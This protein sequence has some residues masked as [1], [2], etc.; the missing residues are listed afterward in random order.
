[1]IPLS[2]H[3][4]LCYAANEFLSLLLWL[5]ALC[6]YQAVAK[7]SLSVSLHRSSHSSLLLLFFVVI[8]FGSSFFFI[9]EEKKDYNNKY[10][11]VMMMAFRCAPVRTNYTNALF[12]SITSIVSLFFVHLFLFI[13]QIF[14]ISSCRVMSACYY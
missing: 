11:N 7:V 6:R 9:P 4:V 5:S 14:R 12:V 10:C 3:Y 13:L 1:M 8:V 2:L